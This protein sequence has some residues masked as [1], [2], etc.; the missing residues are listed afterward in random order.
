MIWVCFFSCN[1]IC[2]LFQSQ[3][4]QC[5]T[6]IHLL[7]SERLR[8]VCAESTCSS[9]LF[10]MTACRLVR[11]TNAALEGFKQYVTPRLSSPV[12]KWDLTMFSWDFRSFYSGP[13][14]GGL[15]K[16]CPQKELQHSERLRFL[17]PLAGVCVSIRY[18]ST[19]AS[20][21]CFLY[22]WQ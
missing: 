5:L 17:M 11:Y 3:S 7:Q 4:L 13:Y 21:P 10:F 16:S 6:G 18:A 8:E 22:F 14:R 19:S 1:K 15:M 20:G 2:C 9:S 12:L